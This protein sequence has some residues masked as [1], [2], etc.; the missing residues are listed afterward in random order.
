MNF[1]RL[2]AIQEFAG[3]RVAVY[4]NEGNFPDP[5]I[6][7][8]ADEIARGEIRR[9]EVLAAKPWLYEKDKNGINRKKLI[10]YTG[11]LVRGYEIIANNFNVDKA[12]FVESTNI[13][14]WRGIKSLYEN[15]V[16]DPYK[17]DTPEY[18]GCKLIGE[19][20]I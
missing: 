6:L 3:E 11:V 14:K 4:T 16:F 2:Y 17:S 7:S 18:S 10:F 8:D 12:V 5:E 15:S 20:K 9:H 13:R 1:Y 19:I